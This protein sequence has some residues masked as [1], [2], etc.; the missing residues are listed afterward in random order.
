[1]PSGTPPPSSPWPA[2][3]WW[4]T[5]SLSGIGQ[6]AC[7]LFFMSSH[8]CYFTSPITLAKSLLRCQAI[9]SPP[10]YH[11]IDPDGDCA[12]VSALLS[13]D[14]FL[15][16]PRIWNKNISTFDTVTNVSSLITLE[17]NLA[18]KGLYNRIGLLMNRQLESGGLE[19]REDNGGVTFQ[20]PSR[21]YCNSCICELLSCTVHF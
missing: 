9:T 14:S 7:S 5:G 1:M 20:K 8:F 15:C 6:W 10:S 19:Q 16:H 3:P 18:L 12:T 2:S 4:W 11:Q 13:P 17:L 21:M